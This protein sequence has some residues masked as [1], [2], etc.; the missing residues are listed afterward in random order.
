MLAA[1]HIA[2]PSTLRGV[3]RVV[4]WTVTLGLSLAILMPAIRQPEGDSFPFSKYAVFAGDRDR[5][6]TISTAIA[7]DGDGEVLRLSPELISGTDETILATATV[8]R[9]VAAGDRSLDALCEEI[10]RRVGAS[11]R[12]ADADTVRIVTERYDVVEYF[13]GDDREP[14]DRRTHAACEVARQ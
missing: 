5:T 1:V 3:T 14:V 12:L 4:A 10:A 2:G 11:A 8:R 9:A 6:A 13:A 7:V